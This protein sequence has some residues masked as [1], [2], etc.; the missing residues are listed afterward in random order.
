MSSM[1]APKTT[2]EGSTMVRIVSVVIPIGM[3]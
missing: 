2:I 1:S 3:T